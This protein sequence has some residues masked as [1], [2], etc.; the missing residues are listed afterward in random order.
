MSVTL[1]LVRPARAPD[2]PGRRAPDGELDADTLAR[3]RLGDAGAVRAFVVRYERTVFAFLSRSLGRGVHVEDLAQEV[4][5]RAC[6]A[7]PRLDP[8]REAKV[9][10]WLL[11]I[12]RHVVVDARR[13]RGLEVATLD[14]GLDGETPGTPET[15]RARR[16]LGRAIEV[17][18]AELTA[19]QRDVFILAEFHGLDMLEISAVVGAPENTVKTRLFRARSRLRELL[20]DVWKEER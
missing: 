12:A 8:A 6:R 4:F 10:T 2:L 1:A 7:L 3:C 15:E 17:A 5:L 9:S 19:D 13:R 11:T 20:G 16:A 14:A 18:A